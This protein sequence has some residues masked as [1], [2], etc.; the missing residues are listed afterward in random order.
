MAL[1][2]TVD[3][4]GSVLT[5]M[6]RAGMLSEEYDLPALK[7]VNNVCMPSAE[8]SRLV[9]GYRGQLTEFFSD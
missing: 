6:K 5:A 2:F 7:T 3:N 1:K 9:R 8:K 4:I